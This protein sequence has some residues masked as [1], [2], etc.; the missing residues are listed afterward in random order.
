MSEIEWARLTAPEIQAL[1]ARPETVVILPVASVEQH[2]PHLATGVDVVL[3]T[4]VAHRTARRLQALGIPALVAPCLWTGL[5]EHHMDFGGTFTLD[6]PTFTAMLRGA[7]KSAA[8]HGFRRIAILNGHGGNIE[9]VAL[10][11]IEL[12]RELGVP[13][14]GATYWLA[15]ANEFAP[16]LD[17]QQNVMHACEAE[18]SMMLA[19]AP[20]CV[21][22]DRIEAAVPSIPYASQ[23]A[24]IRRSRAFK[25]MTDTGVLGDPRT[26][27]AEKGEALLNAAAEKLA[28][29]LSKAEF[30]K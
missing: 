5:A 10:A 2:G 1:A 29:E 8:R 11:A 7:A 30:W 6:V 16:L 23:P 4:G 22:M 24:G 28:S 26:A 14:A 18:T 17:R 20:D 25:D 19:L 15:A 27:S 9:A 12:T 21:R 13:V 3:A